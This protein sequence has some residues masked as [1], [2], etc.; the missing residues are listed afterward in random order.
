MLSTSI[1]KFLISRLDPAKEI[2]SCCMSVTK[3]HER[4][5]EKFVMT[6]ILN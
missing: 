4:G 1:S 3:K 6:L 2:D 5:F